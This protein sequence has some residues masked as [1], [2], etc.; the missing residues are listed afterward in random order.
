MA[1][2]PAPSHRQKTKLSANPFFTFAIVAHSH[3]SLLPNW[4]FRLVCAVSNQMNSREVHWQREGEHASRKQLGVTLQPS[5]GYN[6]SGAASK[7]KNI[8]RQGGG[9]VQ[10]DC[11]RWRGLDSRYASHEIVSGWREQHVAVCNDS[12]T[13]WR[14]YRQYPYNHFFP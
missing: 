13:C 2:T 1:S 6:I 10:G 3:F 8:A 4:L 7:G 11:I 14:F 5:S 12:Q 9:A